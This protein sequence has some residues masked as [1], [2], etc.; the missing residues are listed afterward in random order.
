MN[1]NTS[2]ILV[3]K[4]FTI[5]PI[6]NEVV[7]RITTMATREDQPHI[8]NSWPDFECPPDEETIINDSNSDTDP[9][10]TVQVSNIDDDDAFIFSDDNQE[11]NMDMLK[12]SD[13]DI[14]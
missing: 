7:G 14:S 1:L 13:A 8:I 11:Q 10:D 4:D 9:L 3:R 2:R 5:L 6:T 12:D